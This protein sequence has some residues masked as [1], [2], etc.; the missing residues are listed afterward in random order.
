LRGALEA[1]REHLEACGGHEMAA[2]LRLRP[3][4][5]EGFRAA[6]RAH[7]GREIRP[8]Q[9]IRQLSLDAEG[10]LEHMTDGLVNELHRLGPFGNGNRKPLLCL[11]SVSLAGPAR[12]VARRAIICNSRCAKGDVRMKCIAFG[13]GDWTDHCS[14]G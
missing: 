6:F 7:A 3:E 5:F 10:R 9:L 13:A 11:R 14:R 4:K 1:C 12:R 8:E 2:G